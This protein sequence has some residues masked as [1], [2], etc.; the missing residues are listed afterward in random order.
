VSSA[1]WLTTEFENVDWDN[2]RALERVAADSESVAEFVLEAEATLVWVIVSEREHV[3]LEEWVFR[4][5]TL[6]AADQ[7]SESEKSRERENE[8]ESSRDSDKEEESEAETVFTK[9][10][11]FDCDIALDCV[12]ESLTDDVLDVVIEF[13]V[14]LER[15]FECEELRVSSIELVSEELP[16]TEAVFKSVQER[17]ADLEMEELSSTVFV[18]DSVMLIPRSVIVIAS[19]LDIVPKKVCE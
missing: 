14:D 16:D 7:L 3:R 15:T 17:E 18:W 10:I 9:E 2:V 13:E 8:P 12:P 19:E 11:D 6:R 5:L 4:R 1:D